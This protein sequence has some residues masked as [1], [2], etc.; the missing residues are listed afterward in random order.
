MRRAPRWLLLL[1]VPIVL[2]LGLFA[3]DFPR[4]ASDD[5]AP[6]LRKGDLLLACRLCGGPDRGDVVVFADPEDKGHLSIRRIVGAPGDRV[7]VHDG[8]VRVNGIPLV[9]EPAGHVPMPGLDSGIGKGDFDLIEETVGAHHFHVVTDPGLTQ[10]GDRPSQMLN[11]EFFL[12]ADRRTLAHDSRDYGPI[13]ARDIRSLVKRVLHAGN[14]DG[15]R[16]RS[17]P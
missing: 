12:M 2:G 1:L 6:N 8:R 3:F 17:V 13:P 14:S 11:D 15:A 7:E 5:M 9:D 16:Q 4:P 10:S